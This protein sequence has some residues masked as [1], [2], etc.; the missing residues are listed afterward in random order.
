[1]LV[2]PVDY[3][4]HN[5]EKP[6]DEEIRN[7]IVEQIDSIPGAD[8][9]RAHSELDSILLKLAPPEVQEAASRLMGR[10]KWW[11]CA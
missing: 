3:Y 1:M 10:C 7:R 6:M 2:V 9:E 11:A 4:L 5:R 8:P